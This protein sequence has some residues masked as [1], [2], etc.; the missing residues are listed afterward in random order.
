M[1]CVTHCF[2]TLIDLH[3]QDAL[4]QFITKMKYFK[5]FYGWPYSHQQRIIMKN[6]TSCHNSKSY[7]N[8]C[9]DAMQNLSPTFKNLKNKFNIIRINI[10]LLIKHDFIQIFVSQLEITL[11]II[12]TCIIYIFKEIKFNFQTLN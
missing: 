4:P 9:I 5:I 2:L 6:I 1:E 11:K 12:S 10:H 7:T 3:E 8:S